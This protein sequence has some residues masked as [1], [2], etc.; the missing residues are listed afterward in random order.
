MKYEIRLTDEA[1][2]D[3]KSAFQWYELKSY[4]VG[5]R[6]LLSLEACFSAVTRTPLGFQKIHREIRR[7]LLKRFPYGVFYVVDRHQLVIIAVMHHKRSQA[8]W[9]KRR[10]KLV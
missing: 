8:A 3:V 2:E 4:G 1:E 7:T 9:K 6:F 10:T 5:H